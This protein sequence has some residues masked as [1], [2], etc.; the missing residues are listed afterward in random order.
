MPSRR[1][2]GDDRRGGT[3]N[4][5]G[6]PVC[7]ATWRARSSAMTLLLSRSIQ[8]TI[9]AT[10]GERTLAMVTAPPGT[11]AAVAGTAAARAAP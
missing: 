5:A 10:S 11:Q 3:A 7:S 4:E 1:S 2:G 6:R 9:A 8:P